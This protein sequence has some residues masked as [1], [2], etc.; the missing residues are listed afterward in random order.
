M[1]CFTQN[2]RRSW[3]TIDIS[4]STDIS[5]EWRMQISNRTRM[6]N[7]WRNIFVAIVQLLTTVVQESTDWWIFL[8]VIIVAIQM[9]NASQG[10]MFWATTRWRPIVMVIESV[11]N[12]SKNQS[13]EI[14]DY[15]LGCCCCYCGSDMMTRDFLL[16][17]NDNDFEQWEHLSKIKESAIWFGS[18]VNPWGHGACLPE[19]TTKELAKDP[20]ACTARAT[21]ESSLSTAAA[22][23]GQGQR[24]SPCS[25]LI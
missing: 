1:I 17:S 21:I 23:R 2:Q 3:S 4:N 25:S 20:M 15:R 18:P 9:C 6:K 7:E 12:W 5:A 16:F 24:T 11:L 22:S 8:R 13:W 14:E 10:V 19:V